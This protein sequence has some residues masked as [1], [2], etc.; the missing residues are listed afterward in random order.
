MKFHSEER[1]FPCDK[2]GKFFKSFLYLK[3]HNQIH[4]GT[5]PYKYEECGKAF[6]LSSFLTLHMET[7]D[8][9][10]SCEHCGDF[11][12]RSEIRTH[13]KSYVGES[14]FLSKQC[15]KYFKCSLWLQ[16]HKN[17]HSGLKPYK[18]EKCGKATFVDWVVCFSFLIVSS[19]SCLYIL[20]SNPSVLLS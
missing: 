5:K 10:F 20:E 19:I 15:G 4:T 8:R 11:F 16:C 1:P 13:W 17:I 12:V 6:I 18:C 9:K 2:C 7:H 14:P 3:S